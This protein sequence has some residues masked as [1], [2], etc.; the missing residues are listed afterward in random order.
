MNMAPKN[1]KE[2]KNKRERLLVSTIT[3]KLWGPY[4]ILHPC[5]KTKSPKGE[6]LEA[7]W[8]KGNLTTMRQWDTNPLGKC[9]ST[10]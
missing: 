3:Q 8:W 10:F 9:I 2:K 5:Q 7:N 1:G 6:R 4:Q